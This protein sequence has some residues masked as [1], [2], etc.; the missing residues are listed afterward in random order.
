MFRLWH[1]SWTLYTN[2]HDEQRKE[3]V[4]FFL[5]KFIGQRVNM[6]NSTQSL[7][8]DLAGGELQQLAEEFLPRFDERY[9]Q[10]INSGTCEGTAKT[11]KGT[12]D[13]WIFNSQDNTILVEVTTDKAKGKLHTDLEK[14]I[15]MFRK[16]DTGHKEYVIFVNYKPIIDEIEPCKKVC[17]LEGIKFSLFDNKRISDFL[18][19]P[20]NHDLRHKYL[21]IQPHYGVFLT[22]QEF[23]SRM[24][25]RST[26][27]PFNTFF[28]GREH[29]IQEAADLV[30]KG[31]RIILISGEPGVGKTKY[32]LELLYFLVGDPAFKEYDVKFVNENGDI[33]TAI[34]SELDSRKN[35]F[36]VA[37]DANRISELS[38]LFEVL[39][40]PRKFTGSS[41]I[42]LTARNYAIPD[43]VEEI[44]KKKIE[45][46]KHLRLKVLTNQDIDHIVQ[47]APLNVQLQEKRRNIVLIAKG[48]PRVAGIAAQV[49]NERGYLDV[50]SFAELLG[51][52]FEGI[53]T[54][55]YRLSDDS[56]KKRLLAIIAGLR[57]FS[58]NHESTVESI[59]ELIGFES[60][61]DFNANLFE[62]RESEIVDILPSTQVVK[63]FDDSLSEYL[64]YR[65]FFRDDIQFMSFEESIIKPFESKYGQKIF[66]N[67]VSLS[68]K[69]FKSKA[70]TEIHYSLLRNARDTLLT[71]PNV[72]QRVQTLSRLEKFAHCIPNDSFE[73][74][75]NFTDRIAVKNLSLAEALAIVKIFTSIKFRDVDYILPTGFQILFSM[76]VKKGG[77]FE[78]VKAESEKALIDAFRYIPPR[79]VR[80]GFYRF[81]YKHQSVLVKELAHA[82]ESEETDITADETAVKLLGELLKHHYESTEGDYIDRQKFTMSAGSLALCDELKSIRSD[83]VL[84]LKRVYLKYPD[85][86]TLRL[87]ILKVLEWPFYPLL[88]LGNT[89]PSPE[90]MMHDANK[91]FQTWADAFRKET[92]LLLLTHIERI[93]KYISNTLDKES[94]KTFEDLFQDSDYLMFKKFHG[95]YSDERDNYTGYKEYEKAQ[96]EFVQQYLTSITADNIQETIEKHT[97]YQ[98]QANIAESK[99]SLLISNLFFMLGEEKTEI[100]TDVFEQIK[101]STHAL[102]QYSHSLL[103]GIMYSQPE[104]IFKISKE[105]IQKKDIEQARLVAIAYRDNSIRMEF[106]AQDK[107]IIETLAGFNDQEINGSIT[108]CLMGFQGLDRDWVADML[109][110]LS[111]QISDYHL[112]SLL[113]HLD[114]KHADGKFSYHIFKSHPKIFKQIILNTINQKNLTNLGYHL[115]HCLQ[116]INE[117]DKW[118]VFKYFIK[119]TKF[120]LEHN[121][122]LYELLDRFTFDL[123]FITENDNYENILNATID[124]AMKGGEQLQACL[125]FLTCILIK[126]DR[127]EYQNNENLELDEMSFHIF[128]ERISK[129]HNDLLVVV[130][131]CHEI[132]LWKSWFRLVNEIVNHTTDSRVIRRLRQTLYFDSYSGPTSSFYQSRLNIVKTQYQYFGD[133]PKMIRFLQDMENMFKEMIDGELEREREED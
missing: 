30:K 84:L 132:K 14:N 28:T 94:S 86:P 29:E 13:L 70:L 44:R 60:K 119:R 34:H 77:E 92:H 110:K 57:S 23:E 81:F 97:E 45:N 116:N 40:N 85:D 102:Y 65:F 83:A 38:A 9:L 112:D 63:I 89:K 11:R 64:V 55:I 126:G 104:Y 113:R 91:I 90:L 98:T 79:E 54:E 108:D 100:A 18:D 15:E 129:S 117:W 7:L 33:L 59:A 62:L 24:Q 66:E 4:I 25:I 130:E 17:Q 46:Y 115:S 88:P 124:F 128:S 125:D 95:D 47:Q 75:Q 76:I 37:D 43:V 6:I 67:L 93:S 127:L 49:L 109:L 122:H 58:L 39:L 61:A 105:I 26:K 74:I 131:I 56:K 73:L 5:P 120:F 87:Q 36:I 1:V 106:T 32:C 121:Y 101:I 20:G 48:N 118:L 27:L 42:L 3:N 8:K 52:F 114:P 51:E 12:P 21:G 53:F 80:K 22:R 19:L 2:K 31:N 35:Y 10:V 16:S 68:Y 71:S 123:G 103:R 50:S 72:E 99:R 41:Y 78:Q 69:G 82:Y 96:E 107:E 133:S 111:S